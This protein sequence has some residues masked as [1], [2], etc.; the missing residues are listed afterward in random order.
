LRFRLLGP[1]EILGRGGEPVPLR[2]AK[3]RTVMAVLLLHSNRRVSLDRL[4]AALWPGDPPPSAAGNVR[5]YVS[6]LRQALEPAGRDRLPRLQFERGGYWLN[7]LPSDLDLL[8]FEDLEQRGRRALGSGDFAEASH[9]L[10]EALR[11]WRGQ[12]AEDVI[13][14]SDEAAT[15][16]GLEERRLAVEEAWIDAQFAQGLDEEL[17]GQLR[18]MVAA[19]PLREQLWHRLMVAL[20]R[21]GRPADTLAAFQE[22]RQRVVGELGIEPGPQVQRLQRQILAGEAPDS[23]STVTV[24]ATAIRPRQLPPDIADFTGRTSELDRLTAAWKKK[25]T[26]EEEQRNRF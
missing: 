12:P 23:R 3:Q 2:A 9:L 17:I 24:T 18:I 6:A 7:L 11:L 14:H 19:Q 1:L 21:S 10:W 16:A 26:R 13:M 15:I 5:T 4:T 20:Y 22:L 8:V 25:K